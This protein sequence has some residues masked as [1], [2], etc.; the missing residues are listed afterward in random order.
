MNNVALG[1]W[2]S[3]PSEDLAWWFGGMQALSGGPIDSLPLSNQSDAANIT[4]STFIQVDLRSPG[5]AVFSQSEFPSAVQPSA[6]G[7][8]IWLPYGSQGILLAFGGVTDPADM[9]TNG[10]SV[11]NSTQSNN[12]MTSINVYDVATQKW[13]IQQTLQKGEAPKQLAQF[14]TAVAVAADGTGYFVYVYGGYD[15]TYKT[16]PPIAQSRDEIWVLSIPAFE[17]TLINTGN[18]NHRRQNHICVTPNPSQMISIGGMAEFGV[19]LINGSMF[20][21]YDFNKNE[22]TGHYNSSSTD[23][24]VVR[25]EIVTQLGTGTS[26]GGFDKLSGD[27]DP[28]VSSF[29]KTRGAPTSVYS[30]RICGAQPK[31]TPTP[32]P[33]PAWRKPVEIAIPLV[34]GLALIAGIAFC[35]IRRKRK[36]VDAE[37]RTEIRQNKVT[38]WIH[39]SSSHDPPPAES[40]STG[41]TEETMVGNGIE[42]FGRALPKTIHT[43]IYEA[44]S[45][46]AS[47]MSHNTSGHGTPYNI[48]SPA[49]SG[50][51]EI[52][53][54]DRH[55]MDGY[56]PSTSEH[57]SPR[58]HPLYPRSLAG[59]HIGS[60]SGGSVSHPSESLRPN[61]YLGHISP[62]ELPED[63]SNEN[64]SQPPNDF[65]LA[66]H[67]PMEHY[68]N[69]N[70]YV[71][72]SGLRSPE[73]LSPASP[74]ARKPVN[75]S[76]VTHHRQTSSMSSKTYNLPSPGPEEDQRRSTF[77]DSLP[78]QD[79][80][81]SPGYPQRLSARQP[82]G[83][84]RS[85]YQENFDGIDRR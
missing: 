66:N 2:T 80:R 18:D 41:L 37:S 4:S 51:H 6:E 9:Q 78:D 29:V 85:A 34:V 70:A 30:A 32:N 63:K 67:G 81:S 79:G 82:A 38:S 20:E 28:T 33:E 39:K 60:T 74:I 19:N 64:L 72:V 5:A 77:L 83:P 23:K 45:N 27:L 61:P 11:A 10:E 47:P 3:A 65:S 46:M 15:G 31:E 50:S 24:Y 14:C 54:A 84:V 17:W 68:Q 57:M 48:A 26:N 49:L 76:S 42:Y 1:A 69:K 13:A 7:A 8:L 43:E 12:F 71:E 58:N 36:V 52:D 62:Y 59:T 56:T 35:C 40:H 73:T 21:V 22:W 75:T 53:A 44:P 16:I 55:E 25:P